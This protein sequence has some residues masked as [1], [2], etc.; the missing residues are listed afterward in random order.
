VALWLS[1][2]GVALVAAYVF[3]LIIERRSQ[4]WSK[5]ISTDKVPTPVT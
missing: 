5:R 4:E 2:V 3:Y 1:G